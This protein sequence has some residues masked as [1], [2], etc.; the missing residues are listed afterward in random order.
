MATIYWSY[1]KYM[2]STWIKTRERV[3]GIKKG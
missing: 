3:E 1:E 2:Q